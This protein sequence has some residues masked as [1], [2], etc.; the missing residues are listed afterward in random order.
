MS[1]TFLGKVPIRGIELIFYNFAVFFPCSPKGKVPKKE[2]EK[3]NKDKDKDKDK[4]RSQVSI[5]YYK[6]LLSVRCCTI[7]AISLPGKYSFLW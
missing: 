4:D 2:D 1:I 3:D 6:L 7:R 5:T